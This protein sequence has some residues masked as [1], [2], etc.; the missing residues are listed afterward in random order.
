MVF[1]Y[2]SSVLSAPLLFDQRAGLSWEERR[3]VE[4]VVVDGKLVRVRGGS[5]RGAVGAALRHGFWGLALLEGASGVVGRSIEQGRV[6]ESA[7]GFEE[8][9]EVGVISRTFG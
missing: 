1:N 5:G 7:P 4:D 6:F 3:T 2:R 8:G 9:D